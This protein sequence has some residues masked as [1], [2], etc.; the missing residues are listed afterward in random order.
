[1]LKRIKRWACSHRNVELAWARIMIATIS[2]KPAHGQIW[3]QISTQRA[4]AAICTSCGH[5][6]LNQHDHLISDPIWDSMQH[7]DLLTYFAKSILHGEQ[8]CIDPNG[9]TGHIWQQA[10]ALTAGQDQVYIHH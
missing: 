1:M 6:I 9:Q 8:L 3:D 5:H 10:V 7:R 2:A 4:T